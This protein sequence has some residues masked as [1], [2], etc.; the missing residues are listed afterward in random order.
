VNATDLRNLRYPSYVQLRAVGERIGASAPTQDLV[1][2]LIAEELL[3]MSSPLDDPVR[4]KKRIDE[5]LAILRDLDFP[6]AQLNERSGLTLLALLDLTPDKRWDQASDPLCG[7]TPMMDFFAAHYGRQYKPNTRETV[8]RQ[9]VHQ[10]LDAGLIVANPDDPVRPT[11]SPKAVYQIERSALELLRTYG[12]DRWA[13]ALR[14][15]QAA[16]QT[17][18][19]KYAQERH[20]QR[21]PVTLPFLHFNGDRFLGPYERSS[22]AGD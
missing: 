21:I 1:D 18:K 13:P 9:T 14:T 4:T 19:Q 5:A 11:N 7:I 6:R 8:R 20:M 17:L 3:T 12:T 22:G 2:T 10:F 15:Y 16:S